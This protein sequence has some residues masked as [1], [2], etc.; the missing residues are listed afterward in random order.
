MSNQLYSFVKGA[1]IRNVFNFER[2]YILQ[3]TPLYYLPKMRMKIY[4]IFCLLIFSIAS[5]ALPKVG[6]D[7]PGD[8]V[9]KEFYS[10]GDIK[11]RGHYKESKKQGVWFYYLPNGPVEKKEKYR[12]GELQWQ[13]FYNERGKISKTVDKNGVVTER[14]K[15]GC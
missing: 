8:G 1:K 5:S 3:G 14:P 11:I 10:D 13:I 12:G 9:Y 15:C 6:Q 7:A 2:G 4:V